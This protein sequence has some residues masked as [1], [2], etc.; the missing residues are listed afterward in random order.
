MEDE[1]KTP[2]TPEE[3][4][5]QLKE[6]FK[7]RFGGQVFFHSMG[8]APS[9]APPVEEE[10]EG[11]PPELTFDRTPKE[12]KEYLDR[13]VIGQEE[14]KEI[15]SVAV[16]DHYN[17][18]RRVISDPEAAREEYVKQN[19]ILLGPTGVG[20]TYLVRTL[21]DLIG[22]PFVKA[23]I[24]KFSE[25]GYV[26]GDVDD[27][28]R[29]LLRMAD[30]NVT[31][32]ECGIVFLDE[33]DKIASTAEPVGRDV[34]GRGVQTGLL[35]LV[36]ETEV[37]TRSPFDMA[38][39]LRDMMQLSRGGRPTK[40]TINTR[41]ILF[42]V[43]GAFTRLP[44]I[45]EKRISAARVGFG[46]SGGETVHGNLLQRAVTRDFM[47]FGFE[48]EFI[49]RLPVRVALDELTEE[50][51]FRILKLSEGSIVKQYR[52]NF[53]A[54]GVEVAF[55][56]E[57]LR[58]VAEKAIKEC[59]GARGLVTVMEYTLRRFKFH[60]PGSGVRRFAVTRE[61][62]E[63]PGETLARL[64]ADP[65]WGEKIFLE[66]EVRA[67]EES[68]LNTHGIRICFDASAV[69]ET[70][71]MC[72]EQDLSPAGLLEDRLMDYVYGLRIIREHT[73][74]DSFTLTGEN[75]KRPREVLDGWVKEA[76]RKS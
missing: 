12:V 31:L 67:F 6:F 32:A 42:V 74:K 47:D 36:E 26:G 73:G 37:P 40:N 18:V 45:V 2:P 59:T 13:Y 20:K 65:S 41:N 10:A 35:K 66:T 4:Q 61:V 34:S 9:E 25:T 30:G 50:D 52:R 54:Y 68:F 39:Q 51:L 60:L 14:A 76:L 11:K 19:V 27:L 33:I 46:A 44:E 5:K 24:T 62:V 70:V 48:P 69:E 49:G 58:A 3:I 1:E 72:R 8:E 21:A 64:L 71:R 53:E 63:D 28:V 23:D 15:L 57:G 55:T 29:E 22:V 75:L 43:S 16:C 17:H 38:A 56:H 7:K